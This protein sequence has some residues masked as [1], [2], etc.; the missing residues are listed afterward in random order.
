MGVRGIAELP[1][2][3]TGTGAVIL[4]DLGIGRIQLVV[5][6]AALRV[7]PSGWPGHRARREGVVSAP[8][9]KGIA[10]RY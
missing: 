3:A 8:L 9:E 1:H 2:S 7:T 6:D 4:V 10:D 5:L